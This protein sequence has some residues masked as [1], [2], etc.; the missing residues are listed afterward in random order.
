MVKVRNKYAL[1]YPGMILYNR[2]YLNRMK[3]S[4]ATIDKILSVSNYVKKIVEKSLNLDNIITKY[5]FI[6][7]EEI[8][9][10]IKK[11]DQPSIDENKKT[12]LFSGRLHNQKGVPTLIEA[13]DKIENDDQKIRLLISGIGELENIVKEHSKE[14]EKI[15]YLGFLP[16]EDQLNH[17]Y[18]SNVFVAPSTY[19]DACPTAIIEA[20]ALGIPVVS[21]NVGG[22]PELMLNEKTGYLV[23]PNDPNALGE[24][25]IMA[26]GKD[27]EHWKN[28]CIEQSKK[29]DIKKIGREIAE[30]Y[31]KMI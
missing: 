3:K 27:R 19:P 17:L 21:T 15:D 13:F 6:N 18:Q 29:F 10:H 5:N 31:E 14:S 28:A 24:K 16:R 26:L 9:T 20:M 30:L 2:Y 12:I 22:I 11:F 4:L 7:R 23:E 1:F 25:I 8:L